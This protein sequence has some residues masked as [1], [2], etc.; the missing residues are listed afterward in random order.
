MIPI[1]GGY[2]GFLAGILLGVLLLVWSDVAWPPG[3]Q[4][5]FLGLG[6]TGAVV[7]SGLTAK[8]QDH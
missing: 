1:V 3:V 2:M 5:I 7:G 6:I 4:V 8:L